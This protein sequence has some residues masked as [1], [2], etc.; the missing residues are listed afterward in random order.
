MNDLDKGV[1]YSGQ[2]AGGPRRKKLSGRVA[3]VIAAVVAVVLVW[4]VLGG[5]GGRA[6]APTVPGPVATTAAPA[7]PAAKQY[8][9]PTT[10]IDPPGARE[11]LDGF[12]VAWREEHPG[13]RLELFDG[14][15]TPGV[16]ETMMPAEDDAL[17]LTRADRHILRQPVTSVSRP[18]ARTTTVVYVITLE[19]VDQPR[20][21][22]MVA[23]PTARYGWRVSEV[24]PGGFRPEDE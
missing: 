2:A 24:G 23:D 20:R 19:G 6:S 3:T 7:S 22:Q 13:D 21:V 12:V 15:V 1:G 4:L 5:G 9:E 8:P 16:L 14:L 17:G 11:T 18:S 10:D